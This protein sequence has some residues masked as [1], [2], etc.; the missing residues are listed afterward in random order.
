MTDNERANILLR[1]EALTDKVNSKTITTYEQSIY[2]A[3]NKIIYSFIDTEDLTDLQRRRL[4]AKVILNEFNP[5]YKELSDNLMGEMTYLSEHAGLFLVST[6]TANPTLKAL[7]FNSKTLLHG[8]ELGDMLKTNKDEHVKQFK[9]IVAD[10]VTEGKHSKE[11]LREMKKLNNKKLS[12][13]KG[14]LVQS[15]IAEARK[16]SMYDTYDQLEKQGIIKGYEWLA[17][18][19]LRTCPICADLDGKQ[20]KHRED[21]PHFKAHFRC[22]CQIVPLTNKEKSGKR[23]GQKYFTTV[24]G[25]K[26]EGTQY[27]DINYNQWLKLQ[28]KEVQRVIKSN[29]RISMATF[30]KFISQ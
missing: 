24:D 29:D 26:K 22:R 17:T 23:A 18:L 6:F 28:P 1:Y 20:W 16:Q 14:V 2:E 5:T 15:A 21:I 27:A 19:E 8:Y 12:H 25:I 3:L 13:V 11:V 10:A 7:N 9:R 30:N 4:V